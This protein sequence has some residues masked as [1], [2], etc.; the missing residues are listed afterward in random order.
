[1]G[2]K[3]QRAGFDAIDGLTHLQSAHFLLLG[4]TARA[5]GLHQASVEALEADNPYS[6]FTLIRSYAE[7]AAAILYAIGHPKKIDAMLNL[8]EAKVSIGQIVSYANQGS[9]R[10]GQF[11]NIYSELSQY[12]HPMSTSIFASHK[13]SDDNQV[14]FSSKPAFKH[15]SDFLV[16]SAWIV[17]MSLA[18]AHLIAELGDMYR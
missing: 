3:V 10:F 14:V 8:G 6:T 11:K 9:R 7:N 12:A 17:E 5:Q 2:E 16:A 18:N 13:V 4:L 15:D 1:M